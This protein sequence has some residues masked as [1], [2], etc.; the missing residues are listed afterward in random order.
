MHK[1]F[2][3]KVKEIA[4]KKAMGDKAMKGVPKNMSMGSYKSMP[5]KNEK[6]RV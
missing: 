6:E 5:T 3:D 1:G 2:A 4:K